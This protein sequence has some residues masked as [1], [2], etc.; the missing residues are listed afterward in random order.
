L[1]FFFLPWGLERYVD[2]L[3]Q[4]LVSSRVVFLML[5]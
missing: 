3:H 2:F 4:V 5:T 1:P